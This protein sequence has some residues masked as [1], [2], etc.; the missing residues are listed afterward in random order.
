[1]LKNFNLSV[2]PPNNPG[3][4]LRL[5]LG[6]LAAANL[7]A[8][9][10]VIRPIGGSPEELRQQAAEMRTQIHQQQAALDRLRLF[11][12]KVEGGRGE[13]DQFMSKYFLPRRTAFSTLLG[14]LNEVASQAK[15]TPKESANVIEPVEGTDTLAMMQMTLN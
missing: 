5:G 8:G 1:M 7:V 3:A 6:L 9:Y 14:E 10:F 11:S 15:V 4:L 2:W 12:G 13:G